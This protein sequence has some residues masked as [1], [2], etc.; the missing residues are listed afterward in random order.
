MSDTN[1]LAGFGGLTVVGRQFKHTREDLTVANAVLISDEKKIIDGHGRVEAAK[2]LVLRQFP[3]V[4]LSSL[5]RADRIA[6]LPSLASTLTIAAIFGN[7]PAGEQRRLANEILKGAAC[8]ATQ[9]ARLV[10]ASRKIA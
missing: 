4:R 8:R 3:T 5:T 9:I 2:Q 10:S 6:C 1:A 7:M